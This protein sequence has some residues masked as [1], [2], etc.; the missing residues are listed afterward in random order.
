[1]RHCEASSSKV[2]GHWLK[3]NTTGRQLVLRFQMYLKPNIAKQAETCRHTRANLR[4]QNERLKR[5]KI[6]VIRSCSATT[7]SAQSPVWHCK[8]CPQCFFQSNLTWHLLEGGKP[9]VKDGRVHLARRID[10]H[11]RSEFVMFVDQT[12]TQAKHAF[13]GRVLCEKRRATCAAK[14]FSHC[15]TSI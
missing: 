12:G 3:K 8:T 5:K 2:V 9:V 11:L 1:M 7:A 10:I 14:M 6:I 4:S 15:G 13:A